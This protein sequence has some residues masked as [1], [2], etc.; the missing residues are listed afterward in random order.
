MENMAEVIEA[1][2]NTDMPVGEALPMIPQVRVKPM[3][4][5]GSCVLLVN[6]RIPR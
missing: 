6:D 3:P 5:I 1:L 4:D 2:A